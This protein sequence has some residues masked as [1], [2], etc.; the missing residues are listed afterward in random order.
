ME[1]W[2]RIC[3]LSSVY[4][5]AA[6]IFG[7]LSSMWRSLSEGLTE[8]WY[9]ELVLVNN[10][11]DYETGK[12]VDCFRRLFTRPFEIVSEQKPG[13]DALGIPDGEQPMAVY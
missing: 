7:R 1:G 4:E 8:N 12:I 5:D 9:W 2:P 13:L 3:H 6:I 10:G 11:S